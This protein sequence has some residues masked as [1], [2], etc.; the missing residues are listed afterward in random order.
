MKATVF[1]AI[2]ALARGQRLLE[3][4]ATSWQDKLAAQAAKVGI[5]TDEMRESF[6]DAAGGTWSMMTEV[7][8]G[9]A[10][11]ATSALESSLVNVQDMAFQAL[12]LS[13]EMVKTLKEMAWNIFTIMVLLLVSRYLPVDI[14]FV[15]VALTFFFG[16]F[17]ITFVLKALA[18]LG[19]LATWAPNVFLFVRCHGCDAPSLAHWQEPAWVTPPNLLSSWCACRSPGLHDGALCPLQTGP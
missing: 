7:S 6:T 13:D 10:A 4:E 15:I 9:M 2:V 3:L 18:F 8:D 14:S 17:L 11:K 16:P 12:K 5:D 19:F 1:V